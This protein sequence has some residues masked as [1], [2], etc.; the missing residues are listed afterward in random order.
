MPRQPDLVGT[1]DA[2]RALREAQGWSQERLA[3]E[4]EMHR[5]MIGAYQRA[6]RKLYLSAAKQILRALGYT[7][8]DLGHE[9]DKYDPIRPLRRGR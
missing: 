8:S 4:A 3:I 6:E 9:L 2:L 5:T 7:W 1:A